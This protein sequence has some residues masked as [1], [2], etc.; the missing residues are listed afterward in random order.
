M[1]DMLFEQVAQARL[2]LEHAAD[3]LRAAAQRGEMDARDAARAHDRARAALRDGQL[4]SARIWATFA[5]ALL[6]RPEDARARA[7]ALTLLGLAAIGT[8]A[9]E[10][11][12]RAFAEAIALFVSLEERGADLANCRYGLAQL[13]KD[14]GHFDEAANLIASAEAIFEE[15]HLPG[16]VAN[17]RYLFGQIRYAQGRRD[18]ACA[19]LEQSLAAYTEQALHIEAA[20]CAYLLAQVRADQDRLA[21]AAALIDYALPIFERLDAPIYVAHAYFSLAQIRHDQGD[22]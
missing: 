9:P 18:E 1:L 17:C 21:E 15:Q 13:R 6:Q 10:E 14:E 2:L 3:M 11:G 8:A 12:G 7:R 5:L 16:D 19:A 4:P 22:V 20:R